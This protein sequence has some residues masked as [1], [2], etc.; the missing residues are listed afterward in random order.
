MNILKIVFKLGI[1]ILNKFSV[2]KKVSTITRILQNLVSLEND[3][4]NSLKM[5]LK[6]DRQIYALTGRESVRYGKGLHTKHEHTGYHN[7]FIKNINEGESVLDIGCGNGF[8]SYDIVINVKNVNLFGIDL[9]KSNIESAKE[10]FQHPNLKFVVG[11]ALTDL[12][13]EK[14]AVVILS[15]VLE[16]IEHREKFLTQIRNKIAPSKYLIRVPLFERDW[17]VPLMKELGL[18]YRVDPTHYIEYKPN[19]FLEELKKAGLKAVTFEICWGEI[20]AVVKAI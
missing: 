4:S 6:L 19:E 15:N 10:N 12:P 1:F 16:H 3:P 11:N 20:W 13:D 18:D 7:F 8:L 9:N 2:D 5:L 17:R 14:F